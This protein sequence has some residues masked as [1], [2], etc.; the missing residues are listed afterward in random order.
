MG[1]TNP[2]YRDAL[3]AVETRWEDY[4]RALRRRDQ[5]HYDRLLRYAHDHADAAGHLNHQNP[6]VPALL[7]IDLEQERQLQDVQD[8][9]ADIEQRLAD[10]QDTVND[11]DG[12]DSQRDG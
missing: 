10:R 11:T 2:T 8:R 6:L 1:R 9:L 3:G 12:T 4:R 7:S 5:Q